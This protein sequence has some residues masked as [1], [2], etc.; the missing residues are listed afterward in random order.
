MR[1]AP[2]PRCASRSSVSRLRSLSL[3]SGLWSLVVTELVDTS[4]ASLARAAEC[5]RRGGLVAF[6]TETVYGLGAH[7]LDT[8]AGRRLFEAKGRPANDPLIVHVSSFDDV[9]DLV[10]T[11][12]NA[13]APRLAAQF[14]P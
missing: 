6:A 5:L 1:A 12:N 11:E 3:V 8:A 7:A 2:A 13:Y 10:G 4:P 9:A 14:W